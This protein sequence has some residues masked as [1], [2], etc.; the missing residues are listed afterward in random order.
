IAN[1]F[2]SKGGGDLEG[3]Q[4]L[5]GRIQPPNR[6]SEP[7]RI[8]QGKLVN[9]FVKDLRAIDPKAVVVAAGDFNDF[10]FSPT[11]DALR[12]GRALTSPM[13][14]LPAN[15]RYGYVFNGN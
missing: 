12:A 14:R 13:N 5:E 1:H 11:L 8:E 3:D 9:S 15:E 7:Q 4:P 6:Y 2:S 10:N